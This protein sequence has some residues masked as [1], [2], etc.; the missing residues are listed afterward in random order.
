M[1]ITVDES[2]KSFS[3][4]FFGIA[5]ACACV[6]TGGW[7]AGLRVR[8]VSCGGKQ[9]LEGLEFALRDGHRGRTSWLR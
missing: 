2:D 8:P 6:R 4:F 1:Q 7:R 5:C 9:H 3:S